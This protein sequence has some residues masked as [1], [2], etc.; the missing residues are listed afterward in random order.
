[1]LYPSTLR[2]PI[3]AAPLTAVCLQVDVPAGGTKVQT[4]TGPQGTNTQVRPTQPLPLC[5]PHQLGY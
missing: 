5:C 4:Q 2:S 3:Y 1:M